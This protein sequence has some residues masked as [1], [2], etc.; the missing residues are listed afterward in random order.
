MAVINRYVE[1]ALVAARSADPSSDA[2]VE[3]WT[4]SGQLVAEMLGD[5][6]SAMEPS[7][8]ALFFGETHVV[9]TRIGEFESVVAID[10]QAVRAMIE[11]AAR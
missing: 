5:V 6:T 4:R 1:I 11:G 8:R 9:R 7:L 2:D 3:S 10:G